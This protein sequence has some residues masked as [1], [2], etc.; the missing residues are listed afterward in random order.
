VVHD[1]DDLGRDPDCIKCPDIGDLA[2]ELD[3][4]TAGASRS[5]ETP[6]VS[7]KEHAL[8]TCLRGGRSRGYATSGGSVG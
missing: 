4:P 2:I 3:S 5:A 8:H 6:G 7:R 1:D